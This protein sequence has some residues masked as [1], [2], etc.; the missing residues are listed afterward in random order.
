MTA[1]QQETVRAWRMVSRG[2]ARKARA[3]GI[4]HPLWQDY[5]TTARK[6][7][8]AALLARLCRNVGMPSP[9]LVRATS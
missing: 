4:N 8:Q 9:H 6:A 7:S 1:E 5:A 3:L 2:A